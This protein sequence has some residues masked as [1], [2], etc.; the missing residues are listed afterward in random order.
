MPSSLKFREVLSYMIIEFSILNIISGLSLQAENFAFG[1]AKISL[2]GFDSHRSSRPLAWR[3][4]ELSMLHSVDA[5]GGD[6][7]MRPQNPRLADLKDL[8]SVGFPTPGYELSFL[9]GFRFFK[10]VSVRP[11]TCWS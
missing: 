3:F 11:P 2:P 1:T 5:L 6:N 10:S 9:H 7:T 4:E 8:L